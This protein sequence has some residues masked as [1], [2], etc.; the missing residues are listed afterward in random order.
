MIR[1]KL[2]HLEERAAERGYTMAEV[3]HCII[4]RHSNGEITVD[5]HHPAY[6]RPGL[7]DLVAAGLAAVGIT[8]ERVAAVTGKKD[9]G[10]KKRQAALSRLGRKLAGGKVDPR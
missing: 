6:P 10:C 4:K 5:E 1:C 8:P 3:A 2:H 7:G 9:C